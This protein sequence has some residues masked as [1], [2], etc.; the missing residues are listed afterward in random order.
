MS[1]PSNDGPR[2][3]SLDDT[4]NRYA[5]GD[6]S[7]KLVVDVDSPKLDVALWHQVIDVHFV[8]EESTETPPTRASSGICLLQPSTCASLTMA[9][10]LFDRRLC[11]AHLRCHFPNRVT[12]EFT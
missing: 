4:L 1:P 12:Q 5:S 8:N 7:G 3:V 10:L 6:S 9:A 2:V 11:P